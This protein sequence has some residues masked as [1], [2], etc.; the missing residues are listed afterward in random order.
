MRGESQPDVV[1]DEIRALQELTRDVPPLDPE[2]KTRWMA[3]IQAEAAADR[4]PIASV[5]YDRWGP[6]VPAVVLAALYAAPTGLVSFVLAVGAAVLYA[7]GA[8]A[9]HARTERLAG[10]GSH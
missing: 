2:A 5:G 3:A 8:N 1:H 4:E 7:V 9:L 6:F 10:A